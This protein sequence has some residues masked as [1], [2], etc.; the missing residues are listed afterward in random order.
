VIRNASCRDC[1]NITKKFEQDVAR[2]L[3]GD[4]RTSYNAPSRRKKKR[5]THIV[6]NDPNNP[7][8]KLKVPFSE[9]PAV[10]VF[11]LM[12]RAGIL[13]GLPDTVDL[14]RRW[15]LVTITDEVKLTRFEKKYPGRLTAKFRHVPDSFARLIA[16]IG[17]GQTLCSLDPGD[18]RPI[19]LP[20]IL[21]TRK[22]PSFV[23]GG[24]INIAEPNPEMG[25][26]LHSTG[27]G[28]LNR[29]M[30]ISEVRLIANNHTPTYHVVVGDVTGQ[31]NVEMVI[32]KLGLSDV[33]MLSAV[34]PFPK[35]S[36]EAHHWMP[37]VWPL[38][39]WNS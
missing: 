15:K 22:N 1:A 2:D 20:H 23:V 10:M 35:K 27:F 37:Q 34:N 30:I 18:F 36:S 14:S 32:R 3:W 29:L 13:L 38:P 12:D 25:Y 4:A 17:Y 33:T 21:G 31:E 24:Q 11:Y 6:L 19:C 7:S 28:T 39:Y 9:Y 16:K 8:R 5:S 26:V